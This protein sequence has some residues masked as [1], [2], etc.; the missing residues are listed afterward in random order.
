MSKHSLL[1]LN[2]ILYTI[3]PVDKKHVFYSAK[4]FLLF[5]H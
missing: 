1:S 3:F 2:V 4:I 5:L